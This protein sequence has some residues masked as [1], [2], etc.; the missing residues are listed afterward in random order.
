LPGETLKNVSLVAETMGLVAET[1]FARKK[2]DW[3]RRALKAGSR[4]LARK[5]C[6]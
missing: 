4:I 1:M 5:A 2:L 3:W 6:Q